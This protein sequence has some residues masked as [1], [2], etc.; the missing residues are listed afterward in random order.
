MKRLLT[1]MLWSCAV[2]GTTAVAGESDAPSFVT[3][4]SVKAPV[5]TVWKVWSTPQGY[6]LLG[7]A[8]VDM[9]FRVGGVIRSHYR[10]SGSLGDE[11]TIENRILAYEP[12]HML[13]ICIQRPPRSFPYRKAWKRTWTVVTLTPVSATETHVRIASMGFGTDGES[14][15]M[16]RFFEA[17]NA[18]TLKTL[19]MHFEHL[20]DHGADAP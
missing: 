14:V 11:Q 9:D 19:Q 8:K 4:G 6:Q 20:A 7:V 5:A 17:G 16:Q 3:E 1:V 2:L 18:A 10:S 13:A 15:V 12:Q